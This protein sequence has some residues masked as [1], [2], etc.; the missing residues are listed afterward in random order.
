MDEKPVRMFPIQKHHRPHER[1]QVPEAIYMR[2]YEVYCE[3][4]RPQ[5]ALID[6]ERGCRG[7][8]GLGEL[9]AFL[10]AHSFPKSEWR[11][12]TDEAATRYQGI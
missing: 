11:I 5:E 2:A 12:R 4:F 3:V 1:S 10:Y 9:T 8:F 6:L 7:G